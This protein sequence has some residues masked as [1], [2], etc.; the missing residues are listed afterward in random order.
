MHRCRRSSDSARNGP[1]HDRRHYAGCGAAPAGRALTETLRAPPAGDASAARTR[2]RVLLLGALTGLTAFTIDVSLPALPTM[3]AEFRT[4]AAEA[5]AT[6]S[7]FLIGFAVAQLAAGILSDRFGRRPVLVAGLALFALSGLFCAAAP[8][9][10]G[11]VLARVLQGAAAATG[12]VLARAVA[13]DLF[14]G[15]AARVVLARMTLVMTLAPV[16]APVLGGVL[17]AAVSWRVIFLVLGIAGLVLLGWTLAA[18]PE[19]APRLKAGGSRRSLSA[20]LARLLTDRFFLA[21][22]AYSATLYTALFAYLSGS[23]FVFI[24]GFGLDEASYGLVFAACALAMCVSAALNSSRLAQ[25]DPWRRL[26]VCYVLYV[27]L[28]LAI[29]TMLWAGPVGPVATALAV[30]AM[31]FLNGITIPTQ[32]A[33]ALEPFGAVAGSASAAI[34]LV[35]FIAG[36]ASGLLV[37]A[38]FDGTAGPMLATIALS[39]LA[40]AG[41][42]IP[43]RRIA[44]RH[45]QWGAHIRGRPGEP[46]EG[47]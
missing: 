12:P 2:G 44:A 33:V 42:H 20:D 8:S 32:V 14:E 47:C 41:L 9:L 35:T 17:V 39:L 38:L 22:L 6:L 18:L 36:A 4:S 21:M 45:P 23:S 40:S 31:L 37:N 1:G 5:Q 46:R 13:R 29:G 30:A 11:L 15:A 43:A 10:D 19:T 34:G 28:A 3:A 24:S 25:G 16:V 26:D 7:G 27:A